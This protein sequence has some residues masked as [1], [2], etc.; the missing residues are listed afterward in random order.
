MQELIMVVYFQS[1]IDIENIE[2]NIY[3]KMHW[4]LKM[5]VLK[6]ILLH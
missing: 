2:H 4:V 5:S 3:G 6:I 1:D